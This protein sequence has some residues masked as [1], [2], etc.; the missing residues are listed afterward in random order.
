[1][2]ATQPNPLKWLWMGL[3]VP[4]GGLAIAV[5][6]FV[7][8]FSLGPEGGVRVTSTME[9]YAKEYLETKRLLEADEK[10]I[11]YYDATITLKGTEAA[12]LTDQR[13]IYHRP[14]GTTSL[15]LQ[16]VARIEHEEQNMIGDVIRIFAEDGELMVIEVAPLNGGPQFLSALEN[17]VALAKR[18]SHGQPTPHVFSFV[19]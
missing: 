16:Q 13:V 4:V 9:P 2:Q 6:G 19:E 18:V 5:I 12:I 17:Q 15:P 7:M 14:G 1:M 3:G 11:A 10:V 8:F